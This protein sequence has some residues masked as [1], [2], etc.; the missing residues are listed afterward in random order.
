[1]LQRAPFRDG[2]KSCP[3]QVESSHV[4]TM[5]ARLVQCNYFMRLARPDGSLN[6]LLSS[7]CSL[8]GIR[9]IPSYETS[10][11]V[12]S[13]FIPTLRYLLKMRLST[14]SSVALLASSVYAVVG[15]WQQCRCPDSKSR[16]EADRI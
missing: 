12:F 6:E 4:L 15:D 2:V 13:L 14:A 11:Q 8:Q 5:A 1:M 3:E 16:I 10:P 9:E 7:V